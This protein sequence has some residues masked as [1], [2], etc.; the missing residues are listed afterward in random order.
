MIKFHSESICNWKKKGHKRCRKP[1]SLSCSSSACAPSSS[2]TSPSLSLSLS[3][4]CIRAHCLI[5]ERGINPESEGGEEVVV[6]GKELIDRSRMQQQMAATVEEQMMVK[7]IREELP[8]ESLPKRIQAALVSKDDWHR[9]Y[10]I[11][12]P[13]IPSIRALIPFLLAS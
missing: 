3:L 5:G 4:L 2:R 9:R 13:R 11:Y 7:A 1:L 6:V 8:W 12:L 10:N